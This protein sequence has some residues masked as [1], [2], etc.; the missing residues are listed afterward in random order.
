MSFCKPYSI[1]PVSLVCVSVCQCAYCGSNVWT[2]VMNASQDVLFNMCLGFPYEWQLMSLGNS[3][4]G[5]KKSKCYTCRLHDKGWD[6]SH[7]KLTFWQRTNN[8]LI[9]YLFSTTESEWVRKKQ[10]TEQQ[11][12]HQ[13][14]TSTGHNWSIV[15]ATDRQ[16]DKT[17]QSGT[18]DSEE[19]EAQIADKT[20]NQCRYLF[21]NRNTHKP[22]KCK[23]HKLKLTDFKNLKD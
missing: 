9:I 7:K 15:R 13:T 6:W 22:T 12:I 19:I 17:D 14:N 2:T 1:V 20:Y 23:W 11:V 3:R 16:T 18:V 10:M 5:N 21:S 8:V 4:E